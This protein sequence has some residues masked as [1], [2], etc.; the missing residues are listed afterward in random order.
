MAEKKTTL[1]HPL[2]R[3]SLVRYAKVLA[4]MGLILFLSMSIVSN[5]ASPEIDESP[6]L[7]LQIDYSIP[8]FP[9]DLPNKDTAPD[10]P[11][12]A[13]LASLRKV[14]DTQPYMFEFFNKSGSD[15][16]L[17]LLNCERTYSQPDETL[18]LNPWVTLKFPTELGDRGGIESDSPFNDIYQG[19]GVHL[20]WLLESDKTATYIGK[21]NF[22]E[23]R[24]TILKVG[25]SDEDQVKFKHQITFK[26]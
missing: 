25:D 9:E 26:D 23:H 7:Q 14:A 13:E 17:L 5:L 16:W 10:F 18:R 19:A 22:F 24:T 11:S 6:A 20:I 8:L 15:F 2:A 1:S 3:G 12:Q 21:V 4:A